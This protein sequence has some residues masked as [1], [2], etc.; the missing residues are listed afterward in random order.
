[1][2]QGALAIFVKTPGFSPVKTRLANDLG[3]SSAETF[4]IKASRAVAAIARGAG[5]TRQLQCYFAVAEQAA[6]DHP[7]WREFPKLWQGSGGLGER[8]EHI[9]RNLLKEH[10][11]VLL[12]GADSPQL[13][14]N[15][16]TA[17]CKTMNL[18]NSNHMVFG[19]SIDGGFWLFGGNCAIPLQHWTSVEYSQ[20]DTGTSFYQTMST[21]GPVKTLQTIQ[22]TDTIEDLPGILQVLQSLDEPL[23]EQQQLIQFLEQLT[24]QTPCLG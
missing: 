9:Y 8:M 3:Q 22:D 20:P 16:L 4:H 11:Y 2:K 7:C 13:T 14:V 5:K 18:A 23:P 19:P 1:M 24:E 10:A 15:H 17:A 12:I 6:L 21:I